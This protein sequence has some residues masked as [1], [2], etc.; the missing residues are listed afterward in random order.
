MPTIA[1]LKALSVSGL[2]S[3]DQVKVLGYY[4]AGDAAGVRTYVYASASSATDNGGTVIAPTSGSGRWLL[5]WTGLLNPYLF[6]CYGDNSH[7]DTTA[8]QTAI[9]NCGG[10]LFVP[11]GTYLVDA[12]AL[13]S[14]IK[15]T[16]A[17]QRSSILVGNG[18]SPVIE[19]V[20]GENN[21]QISGISINGNSTASTCA[22]FGGGTSGTS[23][24]HL[25]IDECGFYGATSVN[26]DLEFVNYGSI[27]KCQITNC[28]NAGNTGIG[29]KF[30]NCEEIATEKNELVDNNI[31]VSVLNNSNSLRFSDNSY[32]GPDAEN[33]ISF[34]QLVD[35][36]HIYFTRE[37]F[38]NLTTF[39]DPLILLMTPSVAE[40]T[41]IVF[42]TCYLKG[43]AY[44]Q[45]L[46]YLQSG[47]TN[48]SFLNVRALKPELG[49]YIL[50]NQSGDGSIT[51][52]QCLAL[53]SYTDTSGTPWNASNCNSASGSYTIFD[54]AQLTPLTA[55]TPY[56]SAVTLTSNTDANILSSPISVPPGHWQITGI[57]AIVPTSVT[58]YF[59]GGAS[60]TSA[61]LGP[62]GTFFSED[63][64]LS[65]P[66]TAQEIPIPPQTVYL[67]QST[68][69]YLV[70]R[71]GFTG[72]QTA[73][74]FLQVTPAP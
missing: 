27:N 66:P 29:I 15:I 47:V 67:T 74:G 37:T 72:T 62:D 39:G 25:I 53:S 38:E 43:T 60:S 5:C 14:N 69:Y 31:Y 55:S 18:S 34:I 63:L 70:V 2:S 21:D 64:N 51:I 46:F 35:C 45:D 24:S 13:P 26:L 17:G 65:T 1:A 23:F 22:T 4:A 44:A 58:S 73:W 8:F 42:D 40:T 12:I 6:G 71:A 50:N 30:Y 9:N 52:R 19:A 41:D 7:S 57:V 3:G 68:N 36:V 61:T 20:T 48:V 59:Q 10:S 49:N 33:P 16:G 28:Y 54:P 11:A 56:G 32:Y